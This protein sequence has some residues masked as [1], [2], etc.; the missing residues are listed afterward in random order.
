M[1]FDSSSSG[2]SLVLVLVLGPGGEEQ[3]AA[4]IDGCSDSRSILSVAH[5][6]ALGVHGVHLFWQ[7]THCSLVEPE[8]RVFRLVAEAD[9]W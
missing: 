4:W 2:S 6:G 3:C 5:F 8:S 7:E 9:G 1:R